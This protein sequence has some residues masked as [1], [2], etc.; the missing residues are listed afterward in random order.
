MSKQDY[1]AQDGDKIEAGGTGELKTSFAFE[2]IMR[3]LEEVKVIED[4]HKCSACGGDLSLVGK[5][6]DAHNFYYVYQC[7]NCKAHKHKHE[8]KA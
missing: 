7:L 8:A 3:G 5:S 2:S 1:T 4:E 6:Q